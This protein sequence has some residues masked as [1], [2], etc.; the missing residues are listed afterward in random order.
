MKIATFRERNKQKREWAKRGRIS[1]LIRISLGG[2]K[3]QLNSI[4]LKYLYS[5][6]CSYRVYL[7]PFISKPFTKLYTP[8]LERRKHTWKAKFQ[9]LELMDFQNKKIDLAV[10]GRKYVLLHHF[11]S[12]YVHPQGTSHSQVE[13]VKLETNLSPLQ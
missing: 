8:V 2:I 10:K 12:K 4:K 6:F 7:Y 5:F 3:E 13:F 9:V 11:K 1:G